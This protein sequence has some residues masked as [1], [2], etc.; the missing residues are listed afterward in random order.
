MREPVRSMPV[1]E[2]VC[3]AERLLVAQP[4]FTVSGFRSVV[5]ANPAVFDLFA[6]AWLDAG[7]P[8]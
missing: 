5:G 7:L 1:R 3:A 2:C 4:G 8:A 6:D